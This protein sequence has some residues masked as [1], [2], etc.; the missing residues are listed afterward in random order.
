MTTQI[1]E[2]GTP[3][4]SMGRTMQRIYAYV[5]MVQAAGDGLPTIAQISHGTHTDIGHTYHVVMRLA[6]RNLV[7]MVLIDGVTHVEPCVPLCVEG[8]VA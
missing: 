7:G 8:T 6:R 5:R 2:V 4:V 1:R 3:V